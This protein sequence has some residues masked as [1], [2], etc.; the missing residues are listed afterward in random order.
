LAAV[1]ALAVHL[2][3]PFQPRSCYLGVFNESNRT[4]QFREHKLMSTGEPRLGQ[5]EPRERAGAQTGRKY[6]YQYERT[7][8]AALDLLVDGAKHICVYCDWH[9]DFVA[10]IGSPPTRYVFHQVKGRKSSQGPWKFTDFFGVQKKK[11]AKPAK[12]PAAVSANAI[13]PLML[14]HHK[15]FHNN[16]AGLA[17][18][19]NAGLDPT[20]SQFLEAIGRSGTE[21]DL[22]QDA[23]YAFQH[24]ARAY[25]ASDSPLM[26]SSVELFTWLQGIKVYTDQGNLENPEAALLELANV[27]VDYSEIDLLQRQAKQIGR[28]IINRVRSKVAHSTTVVPASDEQLRKDKG[29]VI[30][31]LLNVLSLSAQAYEQLKAG[32]GRDAVKTLSRLQR[33]CL[34]NGMKNHLVQICEFKAQWD[35]W[36]TIE[37]HFLKSAD[38]MLLE[39]KAKDLLKVGLTIQKVV[40]EAKDIAKQYSGLTA[41]TLTPEHVLGLVFSLA[42][43]SEA[44]NYA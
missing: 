28:E 21:A 1:I 27:V 9:D 30:V 33:F 29:I 25:M 5:I 17:F 2:G 26:T 3:I 14:L 12:V 44:L 42:A 16:C 38:Y 15:N 34:K 40:A 39:S 35:I 10:E 20:L 8:R 18:V 43:Q 22:P 6:E 24:I 32:E 13:V 37:R 19:T 7:A 31:D 36:R 23:G 11:T 41:T 4:A